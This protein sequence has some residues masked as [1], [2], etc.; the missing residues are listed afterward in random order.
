M[1]FFKLLKNLCLSTI[2]SCS[3]GLILIVTYRNWLSCNNKSQNSEIKLFNDFITKNTNIYLE[4]RKE[5]DKN[6]I[7][8]QIYSIMII[9]KSL[10]GNKS[11]ELYSYLD[12]L[13]IKDLNGLKNFVFYL[14]SKLILENDELKKFLILQYFI[15]ETVDVNNLNN[16]IVLKIEEKNNVTINNKIVYENRNA[17]FNNDIDNISNIV[18]SECL[19]NLNNENLFKHST[20]NFQINKILEKNKIIG[21]KINKIS[22]KFIE[23]IVGFKNNENDEMFKKVIKKEK[24]SHSILESIFIKFLFRDLYFPTIYDKLVTFFINI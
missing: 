18:N 8:L 21:S 15:N 23:R 14:I 4:R 13:K 19:K 20:D 17:Y 7:E 3:I 10:T 16:E 12:E 24:D 11:D 5:A 9:L 2:L 6:N 1:I 22:E